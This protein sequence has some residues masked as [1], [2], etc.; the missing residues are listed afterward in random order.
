M[1]KGGKVELT[2]LGKT[3]NT[4]TK[5]SLEKGAEV[6][7]EER[8]RMSPAGEWVAAKPQGKDA[9]GMLQRQISNPPMGNVCAGSRGCQKTDTYHLTQCCTISGHKR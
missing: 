8:K 1:E 2:K 5:P 6:I 3:F 4:R 7:K 9:F